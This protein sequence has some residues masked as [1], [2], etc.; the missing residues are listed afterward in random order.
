[1]TQWT[2]TAAELLYQTKKH[3]SS[4]SV[5]DFSCPPNFHS[6]S[7]M[8]ANQPETKWRTVWIQY[9]ERM[10]GNLCIYQLLL[11][12]CILVCAAHEKRFSSPNRCNYFSLACSYL[13]MSMEAFLLILSLFRSMYLRK[14]TLTQ[15]HTRT[16]Y[17]EKHKPLHF[18]DFHI[19]GEGELFRTFYLKSYTFW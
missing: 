17:A 2:G 1:M 9:A 19:L 15:T 11:H 3:L 8:A 13:Y 7:N 14:H 6:S 10:R 12:M 18:C 4:S 5:S 16:K